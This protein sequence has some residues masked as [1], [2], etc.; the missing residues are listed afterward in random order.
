M[1]IYKR[2]DESIKQY[3]IRLSENKDLYELSWE[4]IAELVNAE[5]GEN[6]SEGYYRRWYAPYSEGFDDG[7]K[8]CAN[9]DLQNQYDIKRIEFE[10]ERMKLSDARTDYRKALRESARDD[11]LAEM[12]IEEVSKIK[13]YGDWIRDSAVHINNSGNDLMVSL[14]DIHFGADI[15]NHWNTYNPE[16]AKE[17]FDKYL[18]NILEIIK[19]H[20][21]KNCYVCCNGDLISG[22]IH[23]TIQISNRLNV[24]QQVM[25]VAE[26]ISWF[27][28]ELSKHFRDGDVIFACV[29]GNHSRLSKKK[30]SPKGERLDDLIPF[31]VK[32]RLQNISNIKFIENDV[33]D[34]FN[35]VNIRGLNY[36]NVHGDYDT[37]S[38]IG[39]LL[40]MI[41]DKVYCIHF[42]H[43]H[44][45]CTDAYQTHKT[46]MS[47]SF[48][49]VDDFCIEHRL[50]SQAEQMVC[51]C[52][53][54]GIICQYPVIVQ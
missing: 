15:K 8:S 19:T 18:A 11:M 6:K 37:F 44:H 20:N 43:L 28:S 48:Q 27:L 1:N 51:V 46:I 4:D 24:V 31:Y 34:T 9:N 3:K 25:G 54:K 16:V 13:P 14:N 36:L 29:G 41:D 40:D 21:P 17:R 52:N 12:L 49:G 39:K 22:N 10:K 30:E 35:I 5:W 45:N 53:D 23:K 50:Y 42:G 7:V 33:D 47:G 2:Q 26:L 32:A 38:N